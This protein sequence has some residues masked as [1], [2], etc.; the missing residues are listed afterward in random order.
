MDLPPHARTSRGGHRRRL[1]AADAADRQER[2]GEEDR[3][4]RERDRCGE[5]G[6]QRAAERGTGD[7]R[8]GP[9]AFERAVALGEPVAFHQPYEGGLVGDVEVHGEHADE[10]GHQDE[11][12]QAER[13]EESEQGGGGHEGQHRGPARV[14]QDHDVAGAAAVHPR[15]GEEREQQDRGLLDGPEHADLLSAGVE[16]DH[17]DERQDD[18]AGLGAQLGGGLA[19]PQPAEVTVPPH[20]RRSGRGIVRHGNP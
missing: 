3:A 18:L 2:Q 1:G 4:R 14:G 19:D 6:H 5:Q 11:E 17:G 9:A 10:E 7:L 20:A 12:R 13:A 15:A 16:R 8:G